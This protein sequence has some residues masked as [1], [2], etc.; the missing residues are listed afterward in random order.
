[1]AKSGAISSTGASS[2][3]FGLIVPLGKNLGSTTLTN[4]SPEMSSS[5]LSAGIPFLAR[6]SPAV[7]KMSSMMSS[8]GL[9]SMI[10][11]LLS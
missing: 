2:Y 3:K 5:L 8:I 9:P 1:M 10:L 4:C 6:N 7:L 11:S